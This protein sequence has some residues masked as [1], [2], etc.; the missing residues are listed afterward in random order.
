MEDSSDIQVSIE[1][2]CVEHRP[3]SPVGMKNVT[4]ARTVSCPMVQWN[5]VF[6]PTGALKYLTFCTETIA[7]NSVEIVFGAAIKPFSMLSGSSWLTQ[8]PARSP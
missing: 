4:V 2:T 3:L 5:F 1:R 7:A 8:I 6:E